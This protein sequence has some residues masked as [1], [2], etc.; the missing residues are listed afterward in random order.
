MPSEPSFADLM[1]R[2]RAGARD[3]DALLFQRYVQRLLGLAR[4]RLWERTRQQVAPEDVVQSVFLSF[5]DHHRQE[6]DLRGP[7]GLW[8]RLLE[9]TLRHCGKWNKRIVRAPRVLPL[10]P[11]SEGA[12]GGPEPAGDEPSPEEAATLADL[13]E[14][15]MRGLTAPQRQALQLKLQGST[16]AEISAKLGCSQTLVSRWLEQVRQKL[17]KR[18]EEVSA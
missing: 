15:L 3:E 14:H 4:S 7:D 11:S 1:T 9:I 12:G 13:L 2:G 16:G 6:V 5:V 18:L 17:R 8:D 10:Q